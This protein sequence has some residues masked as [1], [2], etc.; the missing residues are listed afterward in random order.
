MKRRMLLQDGQLVD[1]AEVPLD[2]LRSVADHCGRLRSAGLTGTKHLR[3]LA[4]VPGFLIE[5]YC[6]DNGITFQEFMGSPEH[7]TR[8]LNDP[9]L[10]HFRV[11]EG[12][13][14]LHHATRRALAEDQARARDARDVRERIQAWLSSKGM[15]PEQL[16]ASLALQAQMERDLA[17]F[18]VRKADRI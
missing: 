5:K 10:A 15:T 13:V 3:C 2:D 16:M 4:I 11:H 12:R 8:M 7:E 17:G 9:A 6:N 1:V 18:I 14:A